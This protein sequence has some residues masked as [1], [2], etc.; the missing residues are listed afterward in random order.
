MGCLIPRNLWQAIQSAGDGISFYDNNLNLIFSNDAFY[1]IVGYDRESY[2]EIDPASLY[3]RMIKTI[4]F[5]RTEALKKNGFF[6]GELRVR[7]KDGHI[8]IYLH[9]QLS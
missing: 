9:V 7:H 5:K 1:S 4:I 6:E 3:H 2:R 8:L